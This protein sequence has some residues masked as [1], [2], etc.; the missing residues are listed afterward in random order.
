MSIRGK[1]QKEVYHRYSILAWSPVA[2]GVSHTPTLKQQVLREIRR[3]FNLDIHPLFVQNPR[4]YVG[5]AWRMNAE[6]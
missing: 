3:E 6:S 5:V 1:V 2:F 4:T